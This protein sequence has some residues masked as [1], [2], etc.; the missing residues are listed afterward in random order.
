M[1]KHGSPQDLA[2]RSRAA[3]PHHRRMAADRG[4]ISDLMTHA[5]P[6]FNF[7]LLVIIT[8]SFR[9]SSDAIRH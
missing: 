3:R 8:G 2:G 4:A 7:V 6:L 5:T 1:A 9:G